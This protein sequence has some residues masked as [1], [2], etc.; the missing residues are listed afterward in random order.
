IYTITIKDAQL[1]AYMTK[2]LY[3][4][5]QI[6]ENIRYADL[7]RSA[8]RDSNGN[9]DSK[10]DIQKSGESA[11][12]QLFGKMFNLNKQKISDTDKNENVKLDSEGNVTMK[13]PCKP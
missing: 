9:P 5:R 7:T 4:E 8:F 2:E 12:L 1:F 10:L 6:A 13:D 3:G 11:L